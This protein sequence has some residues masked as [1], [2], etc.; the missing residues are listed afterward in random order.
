MYH[1]IKSNVAVFF[2][3]P[4][5]LF[6]EICRVV[7]S[8]LRLSL[9]HQR[10]GV[11]EILAEHKQT[12]PPRPRVLVVISHITSVYETQDATKAF[13]KLDKLTRA[14]EGIYTSFAHCDFQILINTVSHRHV[15]AYL[16]EYQRDF[17]QVQEQLSC[18]PMFVG[19]KA[20]DEFIKRINK[21]DWF[22]CIEDDIVIND[23]YLLNKLE[24]F[25][26]ASGKNNALLIPNRYEMWKGNKT[27]IDL[28]NVKWNQWS[29]INISNVYFAECQNPH[30]GLYCL[31][32]PQLQFWM[33]SG[34][35][36]NNKITFV[37]SLES[38]VTG[39][40]FECFSLY[41]PHP[42]NLHFLEVQHWDTKYS[43]IYADGLIQPW[44]K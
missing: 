36:W 23:S 32:K 8:R 19:F 18:E 12:Q 13:P 44:G 15:T 26:K 3:L 35:L 20:Q 6:M 25:N 22:L 9:F 5:A 17:I 34:R 16:P 10:N 31:S 4:V 2:F 30:G 7:F 40:L 33:E 24:E 21:F 27:Y 42:S 39:C 38:A 14:I 43:K 29:V 28:I 1:N 37:G 11:I 41:K